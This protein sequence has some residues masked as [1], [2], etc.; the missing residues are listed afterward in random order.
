MVRR[1]RSDCQGLQYTAGSALA[2][3]KTA[4]P[5][6][7]TVLGMVDGFDKAQAGDVDALAVSA[8]DDQTFVVEEEALSAPCSLFR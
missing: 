7:Q 5:Y 2:D 1:F 8:S 4:A 6:A 3:P